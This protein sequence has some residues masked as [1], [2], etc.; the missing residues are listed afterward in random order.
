MYYWKRRISAALRCYHL[1]RRDCNRYNPLAGD[2]LFLA[3]F[4]EVHHEKKRAD[5]QGDEGTEF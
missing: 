3:R 5:D 2:L 1:A 4:K